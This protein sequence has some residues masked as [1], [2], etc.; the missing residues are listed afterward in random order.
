MSHWV[1]PVGPNY[2]LKD[3]DSSACWKS[4]TEY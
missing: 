3:M 1:D 2:Y 4:A